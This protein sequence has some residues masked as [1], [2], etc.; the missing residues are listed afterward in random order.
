MISGRAAPQQ[1]YVM[2]MMMM[3]AVHVQLCQKTQGIK[4]RL[5]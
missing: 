2:T 1:I 4:M 5:K 3:M